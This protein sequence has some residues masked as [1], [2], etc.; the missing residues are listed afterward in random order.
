[1]RLSVSPVRSKQD[2]EIEASLE[3]QDAYGR[4]QADLERYGR[5]PHHV[6]EVRGRCQE[7]G[8]LREGGR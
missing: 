5:C 2:R 3:R 1:M 7:C 8:D 4:K 6:H